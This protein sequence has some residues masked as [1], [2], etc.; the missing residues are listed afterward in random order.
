MNKISKDIIMIIPTQPKKTTAHWS[1][2]AGSDFGFTVVEFLI[3]ILLASIVTGSALSVYLTQHKQLLVQDEVSDMQAN[4][5]AAMMELTNSIRMAGYKVPDQVPAIIA[6]NTNPDTIVI[7]FDTDELQDCQIEWPM[8]QPSAELRADGHDLTGLY[9]DDWAFIY[10][11]NTKTGEFF[12]VTHVQY[13]SSHIQHN[14]MPLSKAYPAGSKIMKLNR[15]KFY[16]DQSD[17]NHPNLMIQVA[18][19][20]PEIYAENITNLNFQYILSN[21]SVVDVPA[22]PFMIREVAVLVDARNN[23]PDNEFQT[24]Y[25]TR[26]L[27]T[28]VKVRNLGVN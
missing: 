26:S 27:N 24:P 4:I 10:D 21:G 25:R 9:D 20:A 14:T 22:S 7:L 3:A 15:Y 5:R 17:A 1:R 18:G 12:L 16:I 23:K 19:R 6:S 28:R 11:P 8:P 2:I 13:A